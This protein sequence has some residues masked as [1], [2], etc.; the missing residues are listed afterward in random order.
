MSG[1]PERA[2]K[3]GALELGQTILGQEQKPFEH[4][5]TLAYDSGFT[6]NPGTDL[7]NYQSYINNI[8]AGGGTTFSNVF[9]EIEKIT[10]QKGK[11]IQELTVIFFTD[12]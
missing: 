7:N 8:R 1:G 10:S 6:S 4:F 2:L 5:I 3:V 11:A 12:G 9:R